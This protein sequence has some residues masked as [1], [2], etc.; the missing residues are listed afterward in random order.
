MLGHSGNKLKKSENTSKKIH[1]CKNKNLRGSAKMHNSTDDDDLVPRTW[2]YFWTFSSGEE[3]ESPFPSW[4]NLS[5]AKSKRFIFLDCKGQR[6]GL[7][8][9]SSNIISFPVHLAITVVCLVTPSYQDNTEK[10]WLHKAQITPSIWEY[11]D[12]P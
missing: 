3:E 10:E 4:L 6:H 12:L 2:A 8:G 5:P 11:I 1:N 7:K 9:P